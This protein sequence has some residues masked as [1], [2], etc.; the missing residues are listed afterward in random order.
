MV[1]EGISKPL[2]TRSV[3]GINAEYER[4]PERHPAKRSPHP[5]G[6][7]Y[8][9]F[10]SLD[11]FRKRHFSPEYSNHGAVNQLIPGFPLQ[12]Q[13][14]ISST[15]VKS[16]AVHRGPFVS[17]GST[18]NL[19]SHELQQIHD[20]VKQQGKPDHLAINVNHNPSA[21]PQTIAI[22]HG[23]TPSASSAS[24]TSITSKLSHLITDDDK[25]IPVITHT[26]RET[27][28]HIA[29]FPDHFVPVVPVASHVLVTGHAVKPVL[30]TPSNR[31]G[32]SHEKENDD[33]PLA[34]A[35]HYNEDSNGYRDII[36][37]FG[38]GLRFGGQGAGHG[39]YA[40]H[41]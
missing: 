32:E 25:G 2:D 8:V 20:Q 3:F 41:G 29:H 7:G 10:D 22:I 6:V 31:S 26:V 23:L 1:A 14:S 16:E 24:K 18:I 37:G 38:V 30:V 27:E 21:F 13:Q 11:I 36:G 40:G 12:V 9:S 28:D 39:F 17:H 19:V 35:Q 4:Y 33:H 5:L 15:A 34:L